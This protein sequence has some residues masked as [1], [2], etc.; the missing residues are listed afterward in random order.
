MAGKTDKLI[1]D[2]LTKA[3][4]EPQGCALISTRGENGLFPPNSAAKIAAERCLKEGYLEIIRTEQQGKT[5]KEICKL[6]AK[7]IQ[8]LADQQSSRQ[9]LE[10]L[11]RV[12]EQ[13][14]SEVEEIKEKIDQWKGLLH[15]M[16][17]LAQS[18]QP[19]LQS[20]ETTEVL[21]KSKTDAII[22][23]SSTEKILQATPLFVTDKSIVAANNNGVSNGDSK[24]ESLVEGGIESGIEGVSKDLDLEISIKF[25]LDL[26]QKQ[27]EAGQDCPLP[28]LFRRL[29]KEVKLTI[30][31]FHDCLRRMQANHEAY[32][33]PWTGPLY[34]LPEPAFALMVG[35]EIAYYISIKNE[36]SS[37]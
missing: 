28:E 27:A 12:L 26:W 15:S 7:G 9:I 1:L 22:N 18:L 5:P 21:V 24:G 37:C 19:L 29:E 20:T 10:D 34:A 33:H 8:Y 36:K 14:Q 23:D 13:K 35:H 16:L 17:A 2:A 30:G 6:T 32:L 25:Q 11:V 4:G 3:V 31:N